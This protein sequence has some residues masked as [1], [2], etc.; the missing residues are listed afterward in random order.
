MRVASR[1]VATRA[2]EE[3]TR[4]A[5]AA[6]AAAVAAGVAVWAKVLKVG[7]GEAQAGWAAAAV[8]AEG[9]ANLRSGCT[10][11]ARPK[12]RFSQRAGCSYEQAARSKFWGERRRGLASITIGESITNTKC[13]SRCTAM[14][15]NTEQSPCVCV[16]VVCFSTTLNRA[17]RTAQDAERSD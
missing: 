3:A 17:A 5:V 13:S 11:G 1:E 12:R 2:A 4:A 14:M 8:A 9:A 16:C 15:K 10:S 6:T 7:K